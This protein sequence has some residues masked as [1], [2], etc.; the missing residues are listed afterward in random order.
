[1]N[2]LEVNLQK[3][4]GKAVPK[5]KTARF[6]QY[7]GEID[8]MIS[9]GFYHEEIN[10]ALREAGFDIS[11]A[12]FRSMLYRE[13]GRRARNASG[14]RTSPVLQ[15]KSREILETLDVTLMNLI[16]EI[17]ELTNHGIVA[18]SREDL[19]FLSDFEENAKLGKIMTC[20]TRFR[21]QM[22]DLA[23]IFENPTAVR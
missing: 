16:D 10:Q 19:A 15:M 2:D 4:S 5:S 22:Q 8:L 11:I 12:M 3:I 18:A 7:M 13:R 14:S 23:I 6:R 17:S 1:M 21:S 9:Q 20:V